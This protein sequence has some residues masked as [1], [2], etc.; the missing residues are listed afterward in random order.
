MM[1]HQLL[2]A[3]FLPFILLSKP[4]RKRTRSQWASTGHTYKLCRTPLKRC[5]CAAANPAAYTVTA[6]LT[7]PRRLG[8]CST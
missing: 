5:Q 7:L 4:T 6:D 8:H 3:A 1:T 2:Y